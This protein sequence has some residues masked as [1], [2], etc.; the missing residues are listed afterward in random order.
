MLQYFH[1]SFQPI[2]INH[3]KYDLTV[4]GFCQ[5][6]VFCYSP[7]DRSFQYHMLIRQDIV[8]L[9]HVLFIYNVECFY[10]KNITFVSIDARALT[11][12]VLDEVKALHALF[13]LFRVAVSCVVTG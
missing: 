12:L 11:F 4:L 7:E 1:V 8:L 3:F 9:M 2:V 6:A 10:K 5:R 13:A